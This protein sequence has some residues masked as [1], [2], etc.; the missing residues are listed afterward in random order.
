MQFAS[1]E[2]TTTDSFVSRASFINGNSM[3]RN[4]MSLKQLNMIREKESISLSTLEVI[5]RKF[6]FISIY[7]V[8]FSVFILLNACIGYSSAPYYSPNT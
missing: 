8:V 7:F 2:R 3:I 1:G 4:S 5:R 6:K